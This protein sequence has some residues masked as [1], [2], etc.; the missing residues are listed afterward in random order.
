MPYLCPDSVIRD[1][2]TGGEAEVLRAMVQIG[3]QVVQLEGP[4]GVWYPI[5]IL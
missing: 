4:S 5:A 2:K 3:I 1:A